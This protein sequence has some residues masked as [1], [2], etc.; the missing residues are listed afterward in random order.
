M[1][2]GKENRSKSKLHL[3]HEI[4]DNFEKYYIHK[5]D[6]SNFKQQTCNLKVFYEL[7]LKLAF[8][9]KIEIQIKHKNAWG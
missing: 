4:S 3:V 6:L 7:Q 2:V 9:N 5:H 1:I 8:I